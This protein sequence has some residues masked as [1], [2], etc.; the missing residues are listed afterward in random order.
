MMRL[1]KKLYNWMEM[2]SWSISILDTLR[3]V[4][5]YRGKSWASTWCSRHNIIHSYHSSI[6]I[7][8]ILAHSNI[9]TL[10]HQP[11]QVHG[12]GQTTRSGKG[13]A[14]WHG[15]RNN[16]GFIFILRINFGGKIS[17]GVRPAAMF[18][19]AKRRKKGPNNTPNKPSSIFFLGKHPG[20]KK[21][22]FHLRYE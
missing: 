9:Q 1:L 6:Y 13:K 20:M 12:Y 19:S 21:M 17:S 16:E 14:M 4:L 2:V 7:T 8:R 11:T 5:E 3:R 22:T 10:E 18:P 15:R